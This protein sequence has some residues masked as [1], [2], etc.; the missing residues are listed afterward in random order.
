MRKISSK[1][2]KVAREQG[3]AKMGKVVEK[4]TAGFN[5]WYEI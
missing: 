4:K 5:G 1:Q 3:K 2:L